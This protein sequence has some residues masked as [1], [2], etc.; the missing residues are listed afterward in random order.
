MCG[1]KW[2]DAI[3]KQFQ[4]EIWWVQSNV[5]QYERTGPF[6]IWT[7]SWAFN[8]Q[9]YAMKDD[10]ERE[11]G[12]KIGKMGQHGLWM[13]PNWIDKYGFCKK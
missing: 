8:P 3:R 5:L 4:Q 11:G 13:A 12:H 9:L 10:K 6:K 1:S 2:L 7:S